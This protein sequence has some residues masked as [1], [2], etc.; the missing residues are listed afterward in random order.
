MVTAA[1]FARLLEALY[2]GLEQRDVTSYQWADSDGWT[3]SRTPTDWRSHLECWIDIG[4]AVVVQRPSY[5][6]EC[7]LVVGMRYYPDD[8]SLSQ[9]RIHAA[10]RD[11]IEYLLTARL[12]GCARVMAVTTATIE[13]VYE[14]GW[15]E[16]S[17]NFRLYLPRS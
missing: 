4:G 7:R 15:V 12:P 6:H 8:D 9:A 13:G 3:Q 14:G 17:I 2:D 1:Y 11:A 16:V 10:T 5:E